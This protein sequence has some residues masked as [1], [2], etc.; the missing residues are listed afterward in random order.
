MY[1]R[2]LLIIKK[3]S[4]TYIFKM[5]FAWPIWTYETQVMAKRKVGNQ[6]GNLIPDN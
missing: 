2:V 4:K 6:I 1:L 3:F 5:G